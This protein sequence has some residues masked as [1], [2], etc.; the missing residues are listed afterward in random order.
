MVKKKEKE[1]EVIVSVLVLAIARCDDGTFSWQFHAGG[2]EAVDVIKDTDA[3]D[4]GK[5][6]NAVVC[7]A[8]IA[9]G[10]AHAITALIDADTLYAANNGMSKSQ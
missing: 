7:V 10:V 5:S 9:S 1:K 3:I 6:P 4:S 8:D 2:S